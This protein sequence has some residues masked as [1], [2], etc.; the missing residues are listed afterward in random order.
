MMRS[1]AFVDFRFACMQRGAW[2]ELESLYGVHT[3][4][5]INEFA[6]SMKA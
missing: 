1:A 3:R 5:K 4:I 6:A 2:E